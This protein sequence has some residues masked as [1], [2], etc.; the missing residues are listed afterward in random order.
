MNI[1]NEKIKKALNEC[2]IHASRINRASEKM[3]NF[4]PL[5]AEKFAKLTED[6][7]G[8]IDQFVFRFSKLQ[9][10]LGK[11]LFK[12]ALQILEEEV[13]DK[14]FIDILNK[15]EKLKLIKTAENWIELRQIRNDL[16]HQYEDNIEEISVILNKIYNKKDDLIEILKNFEQFFLNR[17]I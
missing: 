15:L 11:K 8:Y 12:S 10:T 14:P 9:D 17:G 13:D 6:E 2:K 4:M 16:T 7:I 5:R 3:K 1:L